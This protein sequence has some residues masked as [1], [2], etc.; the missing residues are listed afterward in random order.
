MTLSDTADLIG[1][2]RY[3][4]TL[5]RERQRRV[6]ERS[7]ANVRELFTGTQDPCRECFQAENTFAHAQRIGHR[8]EVMRRGPEHE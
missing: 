2:Q 1:L 3:F 8:F 7:P 6:L 5:P 4:E